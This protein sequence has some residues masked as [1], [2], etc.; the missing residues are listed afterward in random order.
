MWEPSIKVIWGLAKSPELSLSDEELHLLIQART[1]KE[2]MKK[3]TKHEIN[4]IIGVL[5][6]MKDSVNKE[7]GGIRKSTGNT[8]TEN[9]RKKVYKLAQE[10]GWDKP[11]R[12]NGMCKR[13]FNVSAVEWLNYQQ[14]SKLIEALKK[15]AE[16]QQEG[17]VYEAHN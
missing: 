5:Q 10:L 7:K 17:K 16:R 6:N 14:C 13:M 3:L 8:G 4:L 1:G 9:Q 12:V 11:S 15:M 2:S